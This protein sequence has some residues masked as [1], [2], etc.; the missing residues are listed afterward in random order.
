MLQLSDPQLRRALQALHNTTQLTKE[1]SMAKA[2]IGSIT[3]DGNLSFST[4]PHIHA[5]VQGAELEAERLATANPG[6]E[7]VVCQLVSGIKASSI[8]RRTL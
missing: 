6:T 3:P 7:F 8:T 5:S 1:Q 4:K 2:I